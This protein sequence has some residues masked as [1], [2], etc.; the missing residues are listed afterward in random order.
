MVKSKVYE[1]GSSPKATQALP[2]KFRAVVMIDS[3]LYQIGGKDKDVDTIDKALELCSEY[4]GMDHGVQIFDEH[5]NGLIQDGK[6]SNK[7][8]A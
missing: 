8:V 7:K 4:Q 5:N 2:G 6:I 3:C 1:L